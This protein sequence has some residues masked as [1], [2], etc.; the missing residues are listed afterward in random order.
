M[1]TWDTHWA[2]GW[3]QDVNEDRPNAWR[4]DQAGDWESSHDGRW[5]QSAKTSKSPTVD[6]PYH[7]EAGNGNRPKAHDPI[8]WNHGENKP[9][10]LEYEQMIG[11]GP[12]GPTKKLRLMFK[13]YAQRECQ[14][15][16]VEDRLSGLVNVLEREKAA[17]DAAAALHE[18]EMQHQ[19]Q[20][21]EKA[22]VEC[23]EEALEEMEKKAVRTVEVEV[24][25]EVIKEVIKE[26]VVIKEVFVEVEVFPDGVEKPPPLFRGGQSV[27]QWW[28]GWMSGAY[29]TPTGIKGKTG[30]PAWYSANVFSWEQFCLQACRDAGVPGVAICRE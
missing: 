3:S 15:M 18:T 9:T 8:G 4:R 5:G 10:K 26:V 25:V 14:K 12:Y 28:A 21:M 20:S 27:H 23:M 22:H 13:A 6:R 11:D 30:R 29:E 17:K 24:E 19:I 16:G 7:R 1:S 2:A